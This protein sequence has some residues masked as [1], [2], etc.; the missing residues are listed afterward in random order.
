LKVEEA[1]SAVV[2]ARE[3]SERLAVAVDDYARAER[4]IGEIGVR[5]PK[6]REERAAVFVR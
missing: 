5:L 1:A 6:L 2:R 3:A 4:E